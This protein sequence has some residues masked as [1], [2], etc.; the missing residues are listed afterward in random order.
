MA[1]TLLVLGA[2]SD[3]IFMIDTARAL[4]L[5]VVAVDIDP[6]APG[7]GRANEA[8]IVSTRDVSALLDLTDD[9][10]VR[11]HRIRGVTTM[12]SDI[13]DVIAEL[14]AHLG[15]PGPSRETARLA[16]DK[17]Q[18][19]L[20]FRERGIPIPWFEEIGRF[21]EL[22]AIVAQRGFPLVLK[23]IDRSG[24]RGVFLLEEGCD[25]AD[26]F[27]RSY[28]FS[29]VGRCLVEEYLEGPQISTE[30][31]LFAGFGVTPGFADR[32]RKSVV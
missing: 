32:D 30:T 1:G 29:R 17:H 23:P 11:G 25:L 6:K 8:A 3:Q 16:T 27:A 9:L 18:M 26:L 21:E 5:K 20:R 4:G 7:F 28:A 24:S 31:V 15:T 13:P 19:K 10:R 12:G 14:C 22:A 2:S